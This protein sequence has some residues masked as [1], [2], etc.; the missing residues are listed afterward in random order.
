MKKY[1]YPAIFIEDEEGVAV[2]FP[3]IIGG[4][5]DG[6]DFDEA[7]YMAKDLLR[8][9]LTHVPGQCGT[10][11]TPEEM[12]KLFPHDKIVEVEVTI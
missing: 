6:K 4:V 3:D 7:M 5:T 10:P 9:M 11:A 12:K 2:S 8:L 1:V